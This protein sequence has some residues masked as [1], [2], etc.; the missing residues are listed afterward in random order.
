MLVAIVILGL[1]GGLE[2]QYIVWFLYK[3]SDGLGLGCDI[4]KSYSFAEMHY[5]GL[6]Y[7]LSFI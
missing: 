1:I 4:E 6:S 3:V 5:V 2:L 7:V